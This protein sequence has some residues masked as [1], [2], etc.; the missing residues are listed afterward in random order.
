MV[1]RGMSPKDDFASF[2]ERGAGDLVSRLQRG[3][4]V[5]GAVTHVAADSVFIDL[6]TRADGRVPRAELCDARGN[7]RVK[8]GEELDATVVDPHAE[9][10][11]LLAVKMGRERRL[12]LESLEMALRSGTPVEATVKRAVKAGLEVEVGGA[13]A[14]CPASQIERGYVADVTGYVGQ[15]FGVLVTEIK[16][17]GRSI[18]VSRRR[19]LELERE[20]AAKQALAT[21]EV[22]QDARGVVASIKEY[23]AFVD[24]GGVE[25][26]VHISELASTRVDR[27]E[28]VLAPG[29]EVTVRV[30]AIE[31]GERG[32]RI[33]LSLKALLPE[34]ET[35]PPGADE[36]L[37]AKVV[38]M[39]PHGM[40]VETAR[41]QGLVPKRELDL[42]HGADH[43]RAF[44]VDQ[45]LEV[46]LLDGRPGSYR[47]SQTRV[48][49]VQARKDF[50]AYRSKK[51]GDGGSGGAGVGSFGALLGAVD[52]S[53]LP[54][55]PVTDAVTA[56][57]PAP[58]PATEP[59]TASE[60]ERGPKRRRVIRSR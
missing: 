34:D 21:L 14:F 41:G 2:M 39:L 55:K 26:L 8:V 12:D 35:A 59:A 51:Q 24:L 6:G 19:A 37:S 22:G 56:T 44:G 29:E 15:S 38:R 17:E 43:R 45:T 60:S 23:G 48:G 1:H 36:I 33:R 53:K 18:V 25:G 50:D 52:R 40:I 28:D 58:E 54:S 5:R 42:A 47:F 20:Q 3:D 10:G 46:V 13:R 30:L 32:K 16:E 4:R 49:E 7:L 9:G 57:E 31:D 27:V 11:P